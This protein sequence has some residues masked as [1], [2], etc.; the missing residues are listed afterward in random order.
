[1]LDRRGGA[2]AAVERVRQALRGGES[3]DHMFAFFLLRLEQVRPAAVAPLLS[4]LLALE[5]QRPGALSL[6]TL[7]TA[8]QFCVAADAPAQ[9]KT[10]FIAVALGAARAAVNSSDRAQLVRA[11]N[12]LRFTMPAIAAAGGPALHAQ[13]GALP[14]SLALNVPRVITERAEVSG[15]VSQSADELAQLL[16]EAEAAKD[17]GARKRLLVHAAQVALGGGQLRE[18]FE[19]VM[20]V[21]SA[22]ETFP[23]WRDQ[24]LGEIAGRALAKKDVS[25]AESAA[26][27]IGG[28][29]ERAAA[30]QKISLHF[31]ESKDLPRARETMGEVV[32]LALADDDGIDK[33][34]ALL[35]TI[36]AFARID[37]QRTA[38]VFSRAGVLVEHERRLAEARADA[39]DG[40]PNFG[41]ADEFQFQPPLAGEVQEHHTEQDREHALTRHAGQR[42]DRAEQHEEEAADVLGDDARPAQRAVSPDPEVAVVIAVEVAGGEFDEDEDGDGEAE[43]EGDEEDDEAPDEAQPHRALDHVLV[44]PVEHLNGPP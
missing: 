35:L 18:A 14:A 32:K 9:L 34:R 13:A 10:R 15:R 40:A 5:E 6:E 28:R 44:K 7:S 42:H 1:M 29:L 26:A 19:I 41:A 30:L 16:S 3:P 4:D 37:E 43:D 12:L 24:F 21:E 25:L 2:D 17:A 11:Y 31:F 23:H 36:P 22:G 8:R 39:V 33:A 27:K 20:R 38:A